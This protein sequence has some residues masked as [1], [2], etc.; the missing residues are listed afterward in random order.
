MLKTT[1]HTWVVLSN[2]F[3]DDQPSRTAH[4]IAMPRQNTN[5]VPIIQRK[6]STGVIVIESR[7]PKSRDTTSPTLPARSGI[8]SRL[9]IEL[10]V[11][12]RV[13]EKLIDDRRQF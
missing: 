7:A 6:R 12:R 13:A 1:Y 4:A 5:V 9:E 10:Q 2:Y 11:L 3:Q 8:G